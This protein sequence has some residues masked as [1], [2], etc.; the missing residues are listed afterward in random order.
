MLK[1]ARILSLSIAFMTALS[2]FSCSKT[3]ASFSDESGVSRYTPAAE[4][5]PV[6]VSFEASYT[7]TDGY[8]EKKTYPYI[9]V[10]NTRA[11]LEKYTAEHEGQYNFYETS[12]S[13]GFYD[14]VTP[15]DAVYFA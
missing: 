12:S 5:G 1:P 3:T 8:I 11:E 2:L 10:L 6:D 9:T 7:R 4:T 14:L 13:K 15:Y